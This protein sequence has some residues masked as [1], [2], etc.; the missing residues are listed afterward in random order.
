MPTGTVALRNVRFIVADDELSAEEL[1]LGTFVLQNQRGDA[2]FM[3][4]ENWA[5]LNGTDCMTMHND[6]R[7]LGTIRSVML[8]RVNMIVTSN[9]HRS[10]ADYENLHSEQDRF[11]DISLLDLPQ[12]KHKKEVWHE[13]LTNSAKSKDFSPG[14]QDRLAM[15][16]STPMDIFQTNFYKGPLANLNPSNISLLSDA[17]HIKVKFRN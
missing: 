15:M 14:L 4:P 9:L 13:A 7:N 5:N 10:R 6:F 3:L 2:G 11:P 1:L 12:A 8:F 16:I 17:K